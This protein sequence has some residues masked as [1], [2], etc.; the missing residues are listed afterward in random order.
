LALKLMLLFIGLFLGQV[1]LWLGRKSEGNFE[2]GLD[3]LY[4]VFDPFMPNKKNGDEV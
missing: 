3:F 2:I 1:A 4:Y